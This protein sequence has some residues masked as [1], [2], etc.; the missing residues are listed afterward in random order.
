MVRFFI[1]PK[2]KSLYLSVNLPCWR[3]CGALSSDHSHVFS[4]CDKVQLF[5][6]MVHKTLQEVLRYKIPMCCKVLH[7]C[8][9]ADENVNAGDRYLVKI[10]FIAG[11]KAITRKW[12]RAGL[13]TQEQRMEIIAI[14]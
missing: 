6:K 8:N 9:F 5:W 3:E 13:P 2:V 14:T 7:F 1:T 10:L 11:K 12:G 4:K